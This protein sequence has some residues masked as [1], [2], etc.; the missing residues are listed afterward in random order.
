V[1]LAH[2]GHARI[3]FIVKTQHVWVRGTVGDSDSLWIVVDTGAGASVMDDS[4]ARSIGLRAVGTY[5]AHGAG[6]SQAG[7]QVK[8]P[9]IRLAGLTVE[10]HRLDT[11]SLREFGA[12]S[13]QPMDLILGYELFHD[14]VVRFDY[15]AGVMDVWDA[16]H[17]PRHFEGSEIPM[18]LVDHH[19]YVDAEIDF[20]GR[21][22]ISGRWVIDT[23]ASGSLSITPEI[24][25]RDSLTAA[26]PR[27]ME[28]L[29]R[30]VGGESR[31]RVG[32]ADSFK[33]GTLTFDQPIAVLTP[34]GPGRIAVPGSV[35]NIGGQV[36]MRCRITF[37]YRHH[38][39]Y[40]EPG[41][42]FAAPF[43][44]DMSGATLVRSGDD[45]VVRIVNPE[46]PASEAGLREGDHVTRIDGTP[47]SGIDL[48]A[49]R[50]RFSGA[51]RSVQLD[52]TRGDE[53]FTA[54]L[55]LRRI[56]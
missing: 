31:Y 53:H 20:P 50:K 49:L 6:G 16:H 41:E 36:L 26:L 3:P 29:G 45:F 5:E 30:G 13:G 22:P 1:K 33:L 21:A 8:A 10:R 47:S 28:I 42:K 2:D 34:A 15:A 23:G 46:T 37:D 39:V 25:E 51:G 24:V 35:G 7:T 14:C 43:E 17:A 32:R 55:V 9:P 27:T 48:Q 12:M 4:L 56:I 44:S 40:F 18:T 38:R 11:T 52:V 54:T 19:P